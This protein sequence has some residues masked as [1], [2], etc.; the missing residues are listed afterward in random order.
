M[1]SIPKKHLFDSVWISDCPFFFLRSPPHSFIQ[2]RM[3]GVSL[4]VFVVY[5]CL[6]WGWWL[7]IC[8]FFF[9][10]FPLCLFGIWIYLSNHNIHTYIYI[11]AH[12]I[13]KMTTNMTTMTTTTTIIKSIWIIRISL[14]INTRNSSF[15]ILIQL[16]FFHKFSF[17]FFDSFTYTTN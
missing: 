10:S 5:G 16:L 11:I 15:L 14:K 4:C 13:V 6:E 12:I 17:S 2:I 8:C 1:I 7:W 3:L 9:L